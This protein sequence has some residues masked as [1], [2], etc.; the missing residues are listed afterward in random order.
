MIIYHLAI[1]YLSIYLSLLSPGCPEPFFISSSSCQLFKCSYY[2]CAQ[3]HSFLS[4]IH[5][6]IIHSF[7]YSFIQLFIHSSVI[8][9]LTDTKI[10]LYSPTL[11]P[12]LVVFKTT[13]I[14]HSIL[15][16]Y[17]SVLFLMVPG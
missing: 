6:F 4:I 15:Y 1:M 12:S 16:T 10:M 7:M 13:F 11:Q 8:L 17:S 3:L 2:R 5:S 9:C 14:I